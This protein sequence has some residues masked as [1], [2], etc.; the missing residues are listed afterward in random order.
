M[1]YEG[2]QLLHEWHSIQ[3]ELSEA[4]KETQKAREKLKD[5]QRRLD[6]YV[7]DNLANIT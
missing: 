3:E 5:S 6:T 1:T 7:I 4:E 2:E